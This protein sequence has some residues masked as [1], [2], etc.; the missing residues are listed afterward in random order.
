MVNIFGFFIEGMGTVNDD[1]SM[2]LNAGGKAV[3]GRI[4]TIPGTGA[5]KITTNSTFLRSII[6]VR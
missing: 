4:L 6:L 3:I 5:S 1:G 2:S